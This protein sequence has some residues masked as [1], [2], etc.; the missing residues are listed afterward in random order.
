M[1]MALYHSGGISRHG[2][3]GFNTKCLPVTQGSLVAGIP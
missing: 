2:G 1:A 3:F